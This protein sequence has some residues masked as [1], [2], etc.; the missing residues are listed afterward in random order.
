MDTTTQLALA[1]AEDTAE[2]KALMGGYTR[3]Q[4]SAAFD[5]VRPPSDWK[6]T[7][8]GVVK[9][10]DLAITLYAI[11]FYT[12]TTAEVTRATANTWRVT[13]PGYRAGPAGP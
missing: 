13:S 11:E 6:G 12:A 7:I 10:E 8:D 3:P 2:A 4:L 5:A 9:G 1:V